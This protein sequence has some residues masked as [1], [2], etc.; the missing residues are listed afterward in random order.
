MPEGLHASRNDFARPERQRREN[1]LS[2]LRR[3]PQDDCHARFQHR[4]V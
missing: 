1:R 4:T 3:M 2:W